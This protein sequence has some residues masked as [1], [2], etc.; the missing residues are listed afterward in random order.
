MKIRLFIAIS[1]IVI[2]IISCTTIPFLG[3]TQT[4]NPTNTPTVTL[5]QRAS[6]TSLPSEAPTISKAK[7][8]YDGRWSGNTTDIAS[9]NASRTTNINFEV[10]DNQIT[11]FVANIKPDYGI[12]NGSAKYSSGPIIDSNNSIN[13]K[14]IT[15]DGQIFQMSGIFS[16]IIRTL[17]A[18]QV[19]SG[20]DPVGGEFTGK[21]TIVDMTIP[22]CEWIGEDVS[23]SANKQ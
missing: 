17:D 5:T 3:P 1:I 16:A 10:I 9:N 18:V 21:M 6:N 4:P 13:G 11:N 12:C 19:A 20:M 2:T 22:Q 8:N 7:T 14:Y 23:I 15:Q